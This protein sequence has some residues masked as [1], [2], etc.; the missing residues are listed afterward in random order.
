MDNEEEDIE[1]I[2][3]NPK[4]FGASIGYTYFF[5][6]Q[7]ST[8]VREIYLPKDHSDIWN[9]CDVLITADPELISEKP[10]GKT[11]IK[12]DMPYNTGCLADY[13]Y[14]KLSDFLNDET[15]INKLLGKEN[16]EQS[17]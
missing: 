8:K 12:I 4:E 10:E 11:C 15:I 2:F 6:S 5:L 9:K 7:I 16:E 14:E 3:A 17:N 1:V 13:A